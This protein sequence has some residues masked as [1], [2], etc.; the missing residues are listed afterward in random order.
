MKFAIKAL[1]LL[2]VL[3]PASLQSQ[4]PTGHVS[5]NPKNR[6]FFYW[7]YNR[8]IFSRSNIHVHGPN[9]DFTVYDVEAKDHSENPSLVYL[10]PK[11][12]TIPQFNVRLGYYIA[13]RWSLSFGYDHMKYVMQNGQKAK[14][15]GVINYEASP[16]YAG[17]YLEQEM[18]IDE[19]FLKFEH[20]D[21]LNLVTLDVEHY[22]P[23]WVSKNQKWKLDATIGTGGIWVIPRSDVRVLGKGL[24]NEFHMAGYSWTGKG[25]FRINGLKRFFF[26]IESR[27]GYVSLPSVLVANEAPERADHN[28]SFLEFNG[29]LGVYF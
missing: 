15:S 3:L 29:V 13:K 10:N 20:T 17:T 12:F 24:N 21:G 5:L 9:Y 28:F 2:I 7:G 23:L 18:V 6:F 26:Q 22:L 25:G 27:G 16:K 8:G 14:V 19:D 11:L 4:T 1:S